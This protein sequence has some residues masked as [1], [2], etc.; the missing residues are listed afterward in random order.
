LCSLFGNLFFLT[1]LTFVEDGN[2]DLVKNSKSGKMLINWKKK[3]LVH[4]VISNIKQYQYKPYDF[5]P[6]YQIQKLMDKLFTAHQY[7]SDDALFKKSL[8]LEPRKSL[9]HE[10]A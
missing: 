6:V 10:I 4:D 3:K 5:Q 2:P 1:D 7:Q 8:A 9:K